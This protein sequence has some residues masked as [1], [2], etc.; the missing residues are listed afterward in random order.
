LARP[1]SWRTCGPRRLQRQSDADAPGHAPWYGMSKAM[2][3][4]LR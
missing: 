2:L 1:R 3:D 4:L